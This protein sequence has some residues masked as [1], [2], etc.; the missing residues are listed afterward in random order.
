MQPELPFLANPA[1]WPTPAGEAAAAVEPAAA[2]FVDSV[3]D[4]EHFRDRAAGRGPAR[5]RIGGGGF[6]G[7]GPQLR[8]LAEWLDGDDDPDAAR[9]LVV[10]TGGP[11]VG[12][13]ALLGVLV[14]AA[15]P[16]L[17]EPTR[18]LW[19]A[20]AARPSQNEH[21]AAVHA[22]Q[23]GL[24]EITASLGRQLLGSDGA[25]HPSENLYP[26]ENLV[27]A[28]ARTADELIAAIAR[29][30]APPVIV[31]DALDEALGADQ[32][33]ER[34]LIPLAHAR[35]TDGQPACRLLIGT[36]PWS[37]FAP[38]FDLA[39]Q[40]GE[41]LDLDSIPAAQRRC[42]LA[43]YVAGLL[44]LLPGYTST[45]HRRSR[46]AFADAVATALVDNPDLPTTAGSPSSHR[47]DQ[48]PVRW[49]EF[50][51]AALYTHTATLT[52]ADR[53]TDPTTA[54]A[55]GAAVPR[56][57]PK[58]LE[59]DLRTRQDAP[60]AVGRCSRCLPGRG[61]RAS[62][63]SCSPPRWPRSPVNRVRQ[64]ERSTRS[65]TSSPRS[66]FYLRTTADTDGTALTGCST[67]AW[68]TTFAPTL[69]RCRRRRHRRWPT[70]RRPPG[71]RR[72]RQPGPPLGPRRPL[73]AAPPAQH[74][75]DVDRLDE[76]LADPGFLVRKT[77]PP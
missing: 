43:D 40:T 17:R 69:G 19:R 63:A 64:A 48:E 14:C 52:D 33:L 37:E 15:H 72:G 51:V 49:G 10:V 18:E 4:E 77:R 66:S 41:V 54:A 73:P 22:R 74:A 26:S 65:P 29:R 16:R 50:L 62:R 11:G 39:R 7:R 44:E 76:L 1:Y 75:I 23:R 59:L 25:L 8:R 28:D 38:L 53:F 5:D 70:P 45:A 68:P 12:K 32:I 58:V 24:A 42:D 3:L 9:R 35:R 71:H 2:R 13:S 46:R 55:L 6:A 36:R 21:L 60:L 61:A 31:L 56:T 34:L 27:P 20:A 67:K 30:P 47:P 57:L